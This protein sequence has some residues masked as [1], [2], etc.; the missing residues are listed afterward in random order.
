MLWALISGLVVLAAFSLKLRQEA[1]NSQ[2]KY[3]KLFSQKK[4]SEVRL[5]QITEQLVPFLNQ[6]PYD[7]TQA[8]FLGRP[9]DYIIFEKDK[10]V[11]VEVKSGNSKLSKKQRLIKSNIDKG[12]VEFHEIRIK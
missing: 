3:K 5:G 9:I 6:F 7:P 11:F 2:A 12:N 4:Q 10:V 1:Q 8:Q